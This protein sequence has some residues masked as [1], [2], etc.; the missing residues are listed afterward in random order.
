MVGTE[1]LSY[2]LLFFLAFVYLPYALFSLVAECF[3][4]LGRRRDS[5][6]LEEIISAFLPAFLFNVFACVVYSYMKKPDWAFD[7]AAVAAIFGKDRGAISDY[8][9]A[10]KLEA[11]LTYLRNL[12]I[13][14]IGFGVWFGWS[15]KV[16]CSQSAALDGVERISFKKFPKYRFA[17]LKQLQIDSSPS[18]RRLTVMTTGWQWLIRRKYFVFF[19]WYPWKWFFHESF[20]PL[21]TWRA[22]EPGPGV[23]I[24]TRDHG[25][26]WATF[27]G[28]EK[29]T[30]GRME[31]IHLKDVFRRLHSDSEPGLPGC[32]RLSGSWKKISHMYLKWARISEIHFIEPEAYQKATKELVSKVD[33]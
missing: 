29:T 30:G 20:V 27:M 25:L 32:E 16:L 18:P 33:A 3:I 8:I 4:D 26:Y 6:Q 12:W 14:S 22:Q 23:R 15:A 11:P 19:G 2:V 1:L 10:G 5:T 21:F 7:W 24:E 13:I 9:Y 28:Y 31:A 17:D